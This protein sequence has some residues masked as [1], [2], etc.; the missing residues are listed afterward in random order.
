MIRGKVFE[1][2]LL[3]LLPHIPPHTVIH[4]SSAK[5]SALRC[6]HNDSSPKPILIISRSMDGDGRVRSH[7]G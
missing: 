7:G 2:S 4:D 5:R 3:H 1:P 6:D